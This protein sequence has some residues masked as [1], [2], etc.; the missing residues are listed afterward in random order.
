MSK[1]RDRIPADASKEIERE[2]RMN[3]EF[4]LGDAIGQLAGG[5]FMKGG[6]AVS[7]KRQAELEVEEYLRRHL[8][9]P[10]EVLK[11]VVLRHLEASLVD[12]DYRQPLATLARF[13]PTVLASEPLL[14][15][16]VR[17]ADAEWGRVYGERPYFE[18]PHRPPHPD[19]PY[20]IE[21]VRLRLTALLERLAS[22]A[23]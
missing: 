20:T 16:I 4:S 14:A 18:P 13:I 6:S 7:R 3:R 9:D 12:T 1:K 15:D 21:S 17:Q 10:G 5:G 23:A 19:D 11:G 8:S 22:G 2:I